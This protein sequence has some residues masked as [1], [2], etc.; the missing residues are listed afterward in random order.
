LTRE[1]GCFRGALA[2][3]VLAHA[4]LLTLVLALWGR[5]APEPPRLYTVRIVEAPPGSADA[6]DRSASA[7]GADAAVAEADPPDG[8][9]AAPDP[10]DAVPSVPPVAPAVAPPSVPPPQ[11]DRSAPQDDGAAPQAVTAALLLPTPVPAVAPAAAARPEAAAAAGP[12]NPAS[13]RAVP[14]STRALRTG[15]AGLEAATAAPATGAGR[16]DPGGGTGSASGNRTVRL[17]GEQALDPGFGLVAPVEPRYPPA[18]RR[19]QRAGTVRVELEV[20]PDGSVTRLLAHEDTP[21]W[22]FGTATR[23]AFARARF[24]P[25]TVNGEPVRVRWL[26]TVHFRP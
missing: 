24:S 14:A 19:L 7:A 9:F 10:R 25:P 11:P 8:A 12:R 26:K 17:V 18:A 3:S 22:G 20:A 21:G 5:T 2:A 6:A 23:E 4:L 16:S 15:A 1:T 13:S